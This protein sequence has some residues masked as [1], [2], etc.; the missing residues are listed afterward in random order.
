[1]QQEV[2]QILLKLGVTE[3]ETLANTPRRFCAAMEELLAGRHTD[4]PKMTVFPSKRPGMIV[5]KGGL[6]AT[7]L[8]PH[9]LLP[10][11]LKAYFAYIPK[12]SVVGISKPGRLLQWVAGRLVLQEEIGPLFVEEFDRGVQPAGTILLVKGI[13]LCEQIRGVKQTAST[14]TMA[15][16]GKFSQAIERD[17]FFKLV[18]MC[19]ED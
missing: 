12:E 3:E 17:E 18:H 14:T 9:H 19:Q 15:W 4:P 2:R 13:H 5:F 11:L 7:S 8:C 16:S 6:Q 10:Y 1:M